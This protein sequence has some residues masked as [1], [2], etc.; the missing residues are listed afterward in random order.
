[1]IREKLLGMLFKNKQIF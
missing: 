1:M